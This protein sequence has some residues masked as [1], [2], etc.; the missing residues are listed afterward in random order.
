[1]GLQV[2]LNF[3]K[4]NTS[5]Q[6]NLGIFFPNV[7]ENLNPALIRSGLNLKISGENIQNFFQES[8]RQHPNVHT[9][10]SLACHYGR[11]T[12]IN[13]ERP[14]SSTGGWNILKSCASKIGKYFPFEKTE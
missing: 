10:L 2:L 6:D 1:M 8:K 4:L 3:F 12:L 5:F 14:V 11:K 9:A 13:K 7:S